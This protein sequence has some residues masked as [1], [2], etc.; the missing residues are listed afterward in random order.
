MKTLLYPYHFIEPYSPQYLSYADMA[1][2]ASSL[3]YFD[4]ITISRLG[5]PEQLGLASS[6]E[7]ISSEMQK[8]EEAHGIDAVD[9]WFAGNR[10]PDFTCDNVAVLNYMLY[11][12]K[13]AH[14]D[15]TYK[16]L[17][18]EGIIKFATLVEQVP[19]LTF[20][21]FTQALEEFMD[22]PG[23]RDEMAVLME[24]L[25]DAGSIGLSAFYLRDKIKDS[26]PE[27]LSRT[28]RETKAYHWRTAFLLDLFSQTLVSAKL[29]LLLTSFS[30]VHFALRNRCISKLQKPSETASTARST[31]ALGQQ[32][33]SQTLVALPAVLPTS[34]EAILLV[35]QKLAD[36]LQEFRGT[37]RDLA[38]EIKQSDSASLTDKDIANS[39][40]KHFVKPIESLQ[41]KLA[42]PSRD[43]ARNLISSEA[44]VGGLV[45]S[46]SVSKGFGAS[47]ICAA[48]LTLAVPTLTASVKTII[49]RQKEVEQSGLAFLMK[50]QQMKLP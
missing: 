49:D 22:W 33:F 42:R 32:L 17:I 5:S 37:V 15:A 6:M 48:V 30:D 39:V 13:I 16:P 29:D 23:N 27:L 34:P 35:R 38:E 43:L 21:D 7:D 46:L 26:K 10:S 9:Q 24:A 2:V 45:T 19:D 50:A 31:E 40:R 25:S 14:S 28:D 11:R 12:A 36:E 1:S 4:S 44:V 47:D 8:I 3:L 41:R 20:D 18:Q